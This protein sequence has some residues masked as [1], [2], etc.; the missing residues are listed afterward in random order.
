MTNDIDYWQRM[1]NRLYDRV[2]ADVR[3]IAQNRRYIEDH[4]TLLK[5]KNMHPRSVI[6]HIYGIL[7]LMEALGYDK[8][9]KVVTK[10][11]MEKAAAFINSCDPPYSME[12]RLHFQAVWKVFYKELLGEGIYQPPVTAWMKITSKSKHKIIPDDILT[13]QEVITM[14]D[15]A[16]NLRDKF[17]LSLITIPAI[18]VGLSPYYLIKY[19]YSF[20]QKL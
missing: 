18:S 3:I 7:K 16:T 19:G 12:S 14:L 1:A 9:L 20:V 15:A 6:R 17:F 8:D 2:L 5:A 13:E 10:R 11:D 4:V